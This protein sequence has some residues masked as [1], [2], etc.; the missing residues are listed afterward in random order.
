MKQERTYPR[1]AVTRKAENSIKSGHPWIYH[2][3]LVEGEAGCNDGALVDIVSPRGRYLGTGFFNSHS[4]IRIRL[5]ST[6]ANDHFDEAFWE[7]RLRYAWEYRKTVM[8][9]DL[10]CCRV[11]F[12]EADSFPGL[13][14]DRFGDILVAQTLSLGIEQRKSLLFP[15]L[16][17][18]LREDGQVIR[19]IYERNDVSIREREGMQQ[20]K[21]FF[22]LENLATPEST[23]TEIVENGIRYLVDFENGQK[24][25]FFLDQKYNRQAV[26][27]LSRGKRVLDCF[28]HTGSFGLNAAMGGAVHVHS[29]DISETAVEMARENARRNGLLDVMD[30]EAANVFDLLPSLPCGAKSDYDFVILDPPAFTKSRQTVEHAMRGYKEINL[31]AMKLLPRGGYLATCSCSHFMTDALFRDMLRSAAFDAGVSLRQ[32]EARQQSPDHP[33]LWNVPETDY[34]KFYLFQ[35]V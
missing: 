32:I 16:A 29:V 30:F 25:G 11:I 31:R 26:A 10:S 6:N 18:I 14:V 34:L 7:R 12:G 35:I 19:G 21:G 2:T 8:G 28:T 17:R 33:I 27:R 23:Q 9:D 22:P 1:V 24:T 5:L 13:T 4:K 20:N 15:M 3:E